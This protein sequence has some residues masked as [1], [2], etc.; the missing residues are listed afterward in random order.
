MNVIT[1]I[2]EAQREL[3]IYIYHGWQNDLIFW[4][5]PAQELIVDIWPGGGGGV[6]TLPNLSD[7][8][9]EGG[10]LT[11]GGVSTVDYGIIFNYEKA[12]W[13]YSHCAVHT[14]I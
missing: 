12:C 6:S 14:L 13:L 4:E 2:C 5:K 11:G 3:A 1:G 8:K 7:V 9:N 10:I